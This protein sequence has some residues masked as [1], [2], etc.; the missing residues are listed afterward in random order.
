MLI[1]PLIYSE[2]RNVSFVLSMP[3]L[4]AKLSWIPSDSHLSLLPELAVIAGE[5]T[6]QN[7]TGRMEFLYRSTCHP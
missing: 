5:K 3:L 1:M 7:K 6:K 4:H 2:L